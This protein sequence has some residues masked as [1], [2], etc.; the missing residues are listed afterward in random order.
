MG[1][2]RGPLALARLG[3]SAS[4]S[5]LPTSTKLGPVSCPRETGKLSFFMDPRGRR[6][7]M[8]LVCE[9]YRVPLYCLRCLRISSGVIAN[10]QQSRDEQRCHHADSFGRESMEP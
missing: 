4:N 8:Q 1:G 6:M 7:G 10:F 3:R 5:P 9:R 2:V